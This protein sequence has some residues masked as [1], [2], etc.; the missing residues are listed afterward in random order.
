MTD[1]G[2]EPGL[3]LDHGDYYFF[4][5]S[6]VTGHYEGND[7]QI[8]EYRAGSKLYFY[9]NIYIELLSK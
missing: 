1:L 8:F 6:L 2:F 4:L 7:L 5:F 3:L 9:G